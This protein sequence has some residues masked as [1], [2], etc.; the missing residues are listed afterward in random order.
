MASGPGV[1]ITDAIEYFDAIIASK[2]Q[3]VVVALNG[4]IDELSEFK[5]QIIDGQAIESGDQQVS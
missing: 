4:T 2:T 3:F 1:N 5:N